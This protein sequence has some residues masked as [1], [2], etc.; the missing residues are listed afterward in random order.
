VTAAL[1]KVVELCPRAADAFEA[2]TWA[3]G[4]DPV[5]AGQKLAGVNAYV[6]E[7]RGAPSIK[8]PSI[9]VLYT[10]ND[11]CVT[12]LSIRFEHDG[13]IVHSAMFAT[14]AA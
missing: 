1:G 12:L 14:R 9:A 6:A 3:L 10:F 8:V 2:L 11:E 7:M 13:L 5:G 4:R